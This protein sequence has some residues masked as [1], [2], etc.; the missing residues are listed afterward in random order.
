MLDYEKKVMDELEEQEA[1]VRQAKAKIEEDGLRRKSRE[2]LLSPTK[3]LDRRIE[4][5]NNYI[6]N[7]YYVV[8]D[9]ENRRKE[10]EKAEEELDA[11]IEQILIQRQSS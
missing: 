1:A 9:S 5:A 11:E 4:E 2:K 7:L 6:N 3:K 8:S 10:L